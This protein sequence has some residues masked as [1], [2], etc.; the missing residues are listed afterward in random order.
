MRI[1]EELAPQV[2]WAAVFVLGLIAAVYA[3]WTAVFRRVQ[4]E[5]FEP[6]SSYARELDLFQS[7]SL[8]EQMEYLDLSKD[9]KLAKYRHKL[10]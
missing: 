6:Q 4:Y 2:F 1:L 8:P 10:F 3:I 5:L 9:A 7:L